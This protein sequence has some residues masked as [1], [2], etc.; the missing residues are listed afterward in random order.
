MLDGPT[1]SPIV[2]EWMEQRA[3]REARDLLLRALGK[4]FPGPIPQDVLS[5]IKDQPSRVVLHHWFDQA[6]ELP[7]IEEF[8]AYVRH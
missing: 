4:R 5:L 6:L 3:T 7:T 1:E 2:N 8:R